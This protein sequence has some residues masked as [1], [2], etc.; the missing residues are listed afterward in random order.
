MQPKQHSSVPSRKRTVQAPILVVLAIQIDAGL[1]RG[2]RLVVRYV[3][4]YYVCTPPSLWDAPLRS[5]TAKRADP[6]SSASSKGSV[7]LSQCVAA[8][9][10][11]C[12]P[13]DRVLLRAHGPHGRMNGTEQRPSTPGLDFFF[14]MYSSAQYLHW[15]QGPKL[16]G[17]EPRPDQ[18]R[19]LQWG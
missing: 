7:V 13:K 3:Y 15:V 8:S 5:A 10:L 11:S 17:G 18:A 12:L 2:T 4:C 14:F 16:L 19:R 9:S 1:K 6:R